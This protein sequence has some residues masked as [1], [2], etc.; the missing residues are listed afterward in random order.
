MNQDLNPLARVA[1]GLQAAAAVLATAP[2]DLDLG[3]VSVYAHPF[4]LTNIDVQIGLNQDADLD[5]VQALADRM[6][7]THVTRDVRSILGRDHQ[8]MTWVG[9]VLGLRVQIQT[10]WAGD[11]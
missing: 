8:C 3:S 10:L 5:A 1:A 7:I 9:T 6:R 11:R 2:A 4:G